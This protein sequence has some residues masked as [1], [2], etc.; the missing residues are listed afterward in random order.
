M[1]QYVAM[2]ELRDLR[3]ALRAAG[4]DTLIEVWAVPGARRTE[5]VGLHDGA[6]RLRIAAPPEGGRANRTLLELLEETVGSRVELVKG[7]ASRRKVIRVPGRD[8]ESVAAA[9]QAGTPR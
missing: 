3:S 5:I 7:G 9:L 6:L 4:D 1:R 8:L 2:A